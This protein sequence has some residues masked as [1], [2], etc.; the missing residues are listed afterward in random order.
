MVQDVFAQ[1]WRQA[2]RYEAGRA[3]VAGWILV[4]ARTRAIDR[5][6]A[7]QARPDQ[8]AALDPDAGPVLAS[9]ERSP[10]QVSISSDDVRVV[11]EALAALP[12]TQRALVDLAYFEGLTHSEIAVRTGVPLGTVKTRLRCRDGHA[13]RWRWDHDDDGARTATAAIDGARARR[14]DRGRWARD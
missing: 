1:V 14:R 3:T 2:R 11:R 9:P 5:L 7:R 13:P 12:E 10:E 6:R 4:L 8:A